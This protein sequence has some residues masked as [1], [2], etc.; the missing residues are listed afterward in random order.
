M[1]YIFIRAKQLGKL[2]EFG[3]LIKKIKIRLS[4]IFPMGIILGISI[5]YKIT[6]DSI[7]LLELILL[8]SE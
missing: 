6:I 7:M 3:N 8:T 4:K 2:P 1:D 5:K